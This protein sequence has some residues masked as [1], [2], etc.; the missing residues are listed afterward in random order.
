MLKWIRELQRLTAEGP[1]I[2]VNDEVRF[3]PDVLPKLRSTVLLVLQENVYGVIVQVQHIS[4]SGRCVGRKLA[5]V[6][7]RNLLKQKG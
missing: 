6:D 1:T 5:G 2:F 4:E 3:E 7:L